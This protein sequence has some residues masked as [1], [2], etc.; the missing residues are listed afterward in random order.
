MLDGVV[1][2]NRAT[3]YILSPDPLFRSRL[4]VALRD[5]GF[6][7]KGGCGLRDAVTDA[8]ADVGLIDC[9]ASDSV[10]RDVAEAVSLCPDTD[11]I[12]FLSHDSQM[13]AAYAGGAR[14]A[15]T[16]AAGERAVLAAALRALD[17]CRL[18]RLNAE[19]GQDLLKTAGALE[20]LK[21]QGEALREAAR[22]ISGLGDA[23]E[24]LARLA[25]LA[26]ETVC[27]LRVG[28]MVR[29]EHGLDTVAF[30]GDGLSDAM[31]CEPSVSRLVEKVSRARR[32][33]VGG[34]GR[35]ACVPLQC[36]EEVLGVLA[37]Q[38]PAWGSAFSED[39]VDLL[40]TLG[41][42]IAVVVENKKLY[43]ELRGLYLGTM[44]ALA[45]AIDAKSY[46]TRLHSEVVTRLALETGQLLELDEKD[47]KT[48]E[49][50]CLLHDIGKI[51]V[52]DAVLVK[53]GPL[54]PDEW[55]EIKRHPVKGHE[56]L[57]SSGFL[58][59]I[60]SLVRSHHERYDGKGYPDGLGGR[61]TPFLSRLICIA[62]AFEAMTAERPYRKNPL[63]FDEAVAE[64]RRMAG[65]QF[66]PRL[67]GPF[68]EAARRYC[69]KQQAL[70]EEW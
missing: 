27:A 7:V 11:W 65:T 64:V 23:A 58:D 3:I 25:A 15:L 47:A 62:D 10:C 8:A 1:N 33:F 51:A 26:Q 44:A 30:S 12:A 68:V 61:E 35:T 39:E 31:L 37:V 52:P 42:Q 49:A 20:E 21:R 24:C 14:A 40:C 55:E 46:Y 9:R 6:R 38:R 67:C 59:E 34:G 70:E 4:T 36:G 54:T 13:D 5:A 2:S 48:L 29:G 18:R 63:S 19:L 28:V 22:S 60:A 32:A 16:A 17:A 41:H 50:A 53:P 69:E 56:I 57:A 45:A 66:D 43:E